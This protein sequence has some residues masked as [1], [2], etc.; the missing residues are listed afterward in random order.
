LLCD[1]AAPEHTTTKSL[2]LGGKLGR[3]R[4]T[5]VRSFLIETLGAGGNY[6]SQPPGHWTVDERQANPLSIYPSRSNLDRAPA[7]P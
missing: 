3:W 6:T 2:G 1:T 5:D 4:I 7:I